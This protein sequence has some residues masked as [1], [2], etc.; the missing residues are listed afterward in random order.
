LSFALTQ[1]YWSNFQENSL[2]DII[3]A[4]VSLLVMVAFL[5]VWRPAV[6]MGHDP[7]AP[8]SMQEIRHHSV[9][10]VLRAWSPFL[11]ASVL[12]FAATQPTVVSALNVPALKQPMPWVHQ[13]V[14]R[15]PPVVTTPTPEDAFMD[16]NLLTLPGTAVFAGGIIS[17]LWL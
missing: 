12:I 10:A 5:K 7:N 4:L 13:A 1:F 6:V 15:V 3:A 8:G 9:F 16:L 11:L 2:V 14:R 17:A